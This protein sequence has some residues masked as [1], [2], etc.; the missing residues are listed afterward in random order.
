MLEIIE[1]TF[2]L[3]LFGEEVTLPY[4]SGDSVDCLNEKLNS[5]E[6][7]GKELK[8]MREFFA[9]LGVEEK[10]LQKIQ[11]PHYNKIFASLMPKKN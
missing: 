6:Y 7:K 4:P 5:G 8:L 9:Q 11:L 1:E 3:K 2:T 10:H